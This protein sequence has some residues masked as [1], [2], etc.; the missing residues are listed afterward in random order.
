MKRWPLVCTLASFPII[1][2][3]VDDLATGGSLPEKLDHRFYIRY[4]TIAHIQSQPYLSP[5]VNHVTR[6]VRVPC[7]TCDTE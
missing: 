4:Y 1:L 5:F 6:T 3:L 7:V 2:P